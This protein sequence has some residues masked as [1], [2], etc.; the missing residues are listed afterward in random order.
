MKNV[1]QDNKLLILIVIILYFTL[2]ILYFYPFKINKC[3]GNCNNI[4]NPYAKFRAPNVAKDLNVKVFNLMSGTNET[5]LIKWHEKCK[6]KCRLDAMVCSN[7][8]R[9]N[10]NKCRCE[11][12][13]LIDKG[14]CDKFRILVIVNL[15]VMKIVILVNI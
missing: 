3:S 7:K 11:C 8:Q 1:K 4:N 5:R 14:I 6:C 2:L 10:R 15:N 12:K 13:E 9:W